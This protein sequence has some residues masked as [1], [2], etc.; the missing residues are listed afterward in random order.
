MLGLHD[1]K[2][3][4]TLILLVGEIFEKF[5]KILFGYLKRII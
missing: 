1:K 3:I 2:I 4:M 5:L